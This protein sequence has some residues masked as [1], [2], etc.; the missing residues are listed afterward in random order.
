VIE[1]S[2]G[3]VS[4]RPSQVVVAV[5]EEVLDELLERALVRPIPRVRGPL[6]DAAVVIGSDA[7]VLVTLL[8]APD[9]V[10]SFAS[11]LVDR[12]RKKG[13]MLTI[14]AKQGERLL[15]LRIDGEVDMDAVARFL[16]G[17]FRESPSNQ[18]K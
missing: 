10:R 13:D 11:W 2:T 5:P 16:E 9:T 6:I 8:Q 15:V 18:A 12:V 17:A 1:A 3:E 14:K 7:A 4:P